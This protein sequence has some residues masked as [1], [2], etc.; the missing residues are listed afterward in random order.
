MGLL[1]QLK[2]VSEHWDEL[3]MLVGNAPIVVDRMS[4]Q[5]EIAGTALPIEEYIENYRIHGTCHPIDEV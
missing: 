2:R 5:I 4:A 3:S 1:L